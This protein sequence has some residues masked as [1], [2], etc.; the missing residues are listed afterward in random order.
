M[1]LKQPCVIIH[2]GKRQEYL[3]ATIRHSRLCDG[4]QARRFHHQ[5]HNR[6]RMNRPGRPDANNNAFTIKSAFR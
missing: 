6:L 3:P 1:L 4:N 2:D 5:S